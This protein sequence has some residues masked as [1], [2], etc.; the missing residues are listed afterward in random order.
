MIRQEICFAISCDG[1]C[2]DEGWDDGSGAGV[3]HFDTPAAAEQY[4]I[5][6]G[7]EV[8]DGRAHCPTCVANRQCA[9]TGH[10]WGPWEPAQLGAVGFQRR[11]CERCDAV[12]HD[13]PWSEVVVLAEAARIV[14]AARS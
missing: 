5:D 10:P 4:A 12:E 1:D 11:H 9:A 8:A 6:A 7:W 14:N 13:P 3:P 2:D